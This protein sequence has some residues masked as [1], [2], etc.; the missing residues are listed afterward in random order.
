MFSAMSLGVCV[1]TGITAAAFFR[2]NKDWGVRSV[3]AAN[4][5]KSEMELP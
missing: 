2:L 5:Q 1:A 4:L 3:G